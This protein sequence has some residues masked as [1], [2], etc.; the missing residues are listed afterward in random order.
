[1]TDRHI[2]FLRLVA[3]RLQ[4]QL[5][6]DHDANEHATDATFT[7]RRQRLE[8][9]ANRARARL[10]DAEARRRHHRPGRVS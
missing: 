5:D 2:D 1:M 8:R 6:D 4:R 7:G 9:S 3:D 10:A